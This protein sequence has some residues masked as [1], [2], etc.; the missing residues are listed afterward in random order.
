MRANN[1]EF[2][3]ES[4]DILDMSLPKPELREV[5]L[6]LSLDMY[7][8]HTNVESRIERLSVLVDYFKERPGVMDE[9]AKKPENMAIK[10][11]LMGDITDVIQ[12]VCE[13]A[14]CEPDDMRINLEFCKGSERALELSI[15]LHRDLTPGMQKVISRLVQIHMQRAV[16]RFNDE[17][18]GILMSGMGADEFN[19]LQDDEPELDEDVA[20]A[21]ERMKWDKTSRGEA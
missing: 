15:G 14:E 16:S 4:S 17:H 12:D 9:D 20:K 10:M 3:V 13:S 5:A 11:M 19:S 2:L 21:L 1:I 6:K 18:P 7:A 8:V